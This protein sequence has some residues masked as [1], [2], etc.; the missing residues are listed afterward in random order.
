VLRAVQ[1]A[2]GDL[3][4]LYIRATIM[5]FPARMELVAFTLHAH[6]PLV[7]LAACLGFHVLGSLP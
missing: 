4:Y 2:S 5:S 6:L 1:F 7:S 3:L